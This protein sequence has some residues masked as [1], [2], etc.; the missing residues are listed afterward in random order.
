MQTILPALAAALAPHAPVLSRTWRAPAPCAQLIASAEGTTVQN[1]RIDHDILLRAARGEQVARTPVWL[2]RQA[3]RYMAAFREYSNR[4]PFRQRS[5]S[6]D[7]AI[8]LSLQPWRAFDVD[9]VIMF[10]DILT[11]LPALGVDFDV[12]KGSGPIIADPLRSMDA[13]LAMTPLDDP[14]SKLPFIRTI[15]GDL[16]KETEGRTSLLGFVGAPF[17]LVAYAVEGAANRHC[18]HTKTMMTRNPQLLHAALN[19]IADAIGLY[20]CYQIESGAQVIQFFES[21]AH[22]LGPTQ[23]A[24]YA[25]P[26][27][28]RAMQYVRER[29]PEVPVMYYANGGSSYLDKQRD[30]NCDVISL[31]WACDMRLARQTLGEERV[32]QGNVD[33]TVLLGSEQQIASAVR[34]CISKAG[35][36]GHILNL[37]HG[38]LQGTPEE[39]VRT[40]VQAAKEIPLTQ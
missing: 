36:R 7:I 18:I 3:G 26:Y 37:G 33:P 14:E 19:H 31:D 5:E 10:S 13:V 24:T 17:T 12:V 1:D 21:W 15:L 25:K 11:P 23:F 8:E 16:R 35:G 2:M 30:M 29:H 22:H 28:D 34:D 6:P 4:Y 9:G 27:A 39:A 32:V 40:F 20:A 38:V